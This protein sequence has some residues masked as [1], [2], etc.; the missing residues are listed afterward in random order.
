MAV[1]VCFTLILL[2][3]FMVVASL[4]D[5]SRPFRLAFA[6]YI[7][8]AFLER[9]RVRASARNLLLVV[10]RWSTGRRRRTAKRMQGRL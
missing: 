3:I 2:G 5:L 9:P 7:A 6:M 1:R 4:G 10:A 8:L